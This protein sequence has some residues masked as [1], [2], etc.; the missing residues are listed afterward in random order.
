MG[1][2]RIV[3][4]LS[5]VGLMV[6]LGAAPA[7]AGERLGTGLVRI[8][9]SWATVKTLA[10]GAQVVTLD[11]NA[12]GQWMG[13]VGPDQELRVRDINAER[14]VRAWDLLGHGGA[15]EVSATLTWDAGTS[16]S[17]VAV[18]E[19]RIT[20]RGHLRFELMPGAVLPARMSDMTIN[21]ARSDSRQNRAYPVSETYALTSTGSVGTYLPYA[22]TANE[23]LSD[24]GLRCYELSVVQAAPV[25]SL[26]PNLSCGSLTFASG[27]FSLSL[28]SNIQNG[29][30]LFV[31]TM[32]ASGSTFPFNAVV[33]SW[34]VSGK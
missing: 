30:V 7:H 1:T 34:P 6:A 14:L 22:Y 29:S 28:P 32:T 12:S 4:V 33:A 15:Q 13:E 26:P 24:S 10:D 21:L 17:L 3:S 16:F 23:T 18:R 8:D 31:T 9:A 2:S 25:Q 11:K 5:A 19:P 20:P 27:T